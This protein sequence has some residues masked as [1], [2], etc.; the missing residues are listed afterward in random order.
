M[1]CVRGR[2]CVAVRFHA[3]W[4]G[5]PTSAHVCPS[6]RAACLKSGWLQQHCSPAWVR[7]C[8]VSWRKP[9]MLL[10]P[11]LP[12]RLV[13]ADTSLADRPRCHDWQASETASK[14]LL[15]TEPTPSSDTSSA[16]KSPVLSV[17][18]S[19]TAVKG[20]ALRLSMSC[21]CFLLFY[22][23]S[24]TLRIFCLIY[25][26]TLRVGFLSVFKTFKYFLPLMICFG[27]SGQKDI[28]HTNFT[29]SQLKFFFFL[30]WF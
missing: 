7:S 28:F 2:S 9:K 10:P 3:G 20:P 30:I 5:W 6:Y 4:T 27:N 13:P 24:R 1:R 11:P 8:R 17:N 25:W 12:P 21:I 23:Q 14:L 29:K 19:D 18:G 26:K 16:E 22:F 15:P